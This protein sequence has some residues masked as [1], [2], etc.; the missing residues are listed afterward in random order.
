MRSGH[1]CAF[2]NVPA[3][4]EYK[5]WMQHIPGRSRRP[6]TRVARGMVGVPLWAEAVPNYMCRQTLA[7]CEAGE[8]LTAGYA[9]VGRSRWNGT[10]WQDDGPCWAGG[11]SNKG[12]KADWISLLGLDRLDGE[13][14]QDGPD[15]IR[16]SRQGAG[17]AKR[18]FDAHLS[19]ALQAGGADH[20]L[21]RVQ[22]W[23]LCAVDV[24]TMLTPAIV[25][26]D[27]PMPT[28]KLECLPK[29]QPAARPRARPARPARRNRRRPQSP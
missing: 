21:V 19:V 25:P 24:R 29:P 7:I 9:R 27:H 23:T 6:S 16:M 26:L 17:K 28:R 22:G 3:I 1:P 13:L 11:C 15:G 8:L 12:G 2:H 10:G 20:W 5:W 18:R 4:R 14:P